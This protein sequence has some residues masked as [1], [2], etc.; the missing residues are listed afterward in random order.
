MGSSENKWCPKGCG[1]TG[2]PHKEGKYKCE[3]CG[4]EW[5]PDDGVKV[6]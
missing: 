4:L 6:T 5:N 1:K 2:H 3:R